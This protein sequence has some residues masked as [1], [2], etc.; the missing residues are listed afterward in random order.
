MRIQMSVI[1]AVLG[2]LAMIQ[3]ANAETYRLIS[4]DRPPYVNET[5]KD[6]GF[7]VDVINEMAKRAGTEIKLEFMPWSRAQD[8]VAETPNTMLPCV[9]R[10]KSR[11]GSYSWI[12]PMN[13]VSTLF[14]TSGKPV[15]SFEEAKSLTVSVRGDTQQEKHLKDAGLTKLDLQENP[16]I[17]AKMLDAGRV[18]AWYTH[19]LRAFNVW[20][21]LGLDVS[22]L[23]GGTKIA[24]EKQFLAGHKDIPA[25]VSKKL[26]DAMESMV[27]DGAY[28]TIFAKYFGSAK[29]TM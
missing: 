20:N 22:K 5:G 23:V 21:G 13:E 3:S 18:D 7:C 16:E 28:G 17:S 6:A 4:G 26:S 15:N 24:T 10:S 14:L 9:S 11:E 1:S 12:A 29:P 19:D 2:S 8:Y 25:D 27:K